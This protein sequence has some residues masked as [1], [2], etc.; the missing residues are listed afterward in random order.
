MKQLKNS[1]IL[2]VKTFSC[3]STFN[4]TFPCAG[5][6][7]ASQASILTEWLAFDLQYWS[8][9]RFLARIRSLFS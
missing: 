7:F 9:D 1:V 4:H 2:D 8:I 3:L 5:I 6:Q